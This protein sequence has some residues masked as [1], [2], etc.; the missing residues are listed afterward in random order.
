MCVAALEPGRD[1]ITEA[2][3]NGTVERRE[4]FTMDFLHRVLSDELSDH[5]DE[6]FVRTV[7]IHYGPSSAAHGR[8]LSPHHINPLRFHLM[9]ATPPENR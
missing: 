9:P 6:R 3:V 1:F 2:G 5:Y 4:K 7:S 8:L